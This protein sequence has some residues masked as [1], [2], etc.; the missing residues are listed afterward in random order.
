MWQQCFELILPWHQYNNCTNKHCHAE[1]DHGNPE[2]CNINSM[3][4]QTENGR[5]NQH[6][7]RIKS[8]LMSN[9][10]SANRGF[11][12]GNDDRNIEQHVDNDRED[13]GDDSKWIVSFV[14]DLMVDDW[15]VFLENATHFMSI[16]NQALNDWHTCVITQKFHPHDLTFGDMAVE[17]CLNET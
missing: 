7:D 1:S 11:S 3:I 16:A 4:N 13:F 9:V 10:S 8:P 2:L 6:A 15:L 17:V 5:E 12:C 14:R